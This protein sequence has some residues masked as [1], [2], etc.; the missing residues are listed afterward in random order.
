M[1]FLNPLLEI[2]V[3]YPDVKQDEVMPFYREVLWLFSKHL[4]NRLKMFQHRVNIEIEDVFSRPKNFQF[5]SIYAYQTKIDINAFIELDELSKRKTILQLIYEGLTSLAKEH[6]WDQQCIEDAY[7]KSIADNYDFV[8]HT[9]Y[10][11]SR[12]KRHKGRIRINLENRT[13]K[14]SAEILDVKNN[15]SISIELLQTEQ[16]NFA[17]WR[18]IKEFGWMD[19][20]NFGLKFNNGQIWLTADT[21]KG[22]IQT[23]LKPKKDNEK[24]L[25]SF[26]RNLQEQAMVQ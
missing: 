8:Y 3:R 14:F 5:G 20:N 13:V 23:N 24:Q 2:Y 19:S 16:G 25:L 18:S 7:K 17:W 22:E 10:K 26:L 1:N 12:N 11:S 6:N 15:K 9:D 4:N 21:E